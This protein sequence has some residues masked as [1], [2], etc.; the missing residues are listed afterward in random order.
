MTYKISYLNETIVLSACEGQ[1]KECWGEDGW[2][3]WATDWQEGDNVCSN[4]RGDF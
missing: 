4:S 3:V 1:E 2:W